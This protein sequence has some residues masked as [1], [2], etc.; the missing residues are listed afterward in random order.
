MRV[1][2]LSQGYEISDQPSYNRAFLN[3][4]SEGHPIEFMNIPFMGFVKTHGWDALWREL[5][6]VNNEWKPD[7]IFFQFFHALD[8]QSP[9]AC[10]E[11]IRASRNTPLI[12]GSLGD[13]YQVNPHLF[14]RPPP[15][16]LTELASVAD[17]FFSTSMGDLASYFVRHGAQNIIL[18]PHAHSDDHFENNADRHCSVKK[19]DVV[20]LGSIVYSKT[21][22]GV[23]K[24]AFDFVRR[25]REA[26]SCAVNSYRRIKMIDILHRQYASKLGVYGRGWSGEIS[27]GPIGFKD[28]I[29][30][31]EQGRIA[32]DA[33]P[34]YD[35]MYYTSD[36]PFFIAG[37]GVPMVQFRSPRFDR[38]LRS[39]EHAYYVNGYDDLVSVCERVLR[40]PAEAL[41]ANAAETARYIHERHMADNRVDTILSV[42]EALMKVRSR[43]WSPDQGIASLR[44]W[45]FLPEVDLS[46]ERRYAI[47]NWRG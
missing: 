40:M 36:R 47:A 2:M 18:L 45:H 6:R 14:Y 11:Q 16:G 1:L 5:V 9:R 30:V 22:K 37:A 24:F 3:A 41:E 27:Q 21:A 15:K 44:L 13:L 25:P 23:V 34:P 35:Q 39:D 42:A 10:I 38:I 17:A 43:R 26:L 31:F 19:Y 32:V 7:V 8:T 12:F 28:Q 46:E 33:I 20:M 4:S 29:K